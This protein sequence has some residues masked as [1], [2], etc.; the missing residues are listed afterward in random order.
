M[1]KLNRDRIRQ[2]LNPLV[3]EQATGMTQQGAL[4]KYNHQGEV[5]QVGLAKKEVATNGV[6]A[7][8]AGVPCRKLLA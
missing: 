8:N 6:E 5:L 4:G 2:I 1:A 3:E 7:P